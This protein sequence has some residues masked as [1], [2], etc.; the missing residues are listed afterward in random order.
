MKYP[1]TQVFNVDQLRREWEEEVYHELKFK[2]MNEFI[3]ALPMKILYPTFSIY[4]KMNFLK[5]F[6]NH[7]RFSVTLSI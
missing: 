1:V 5:L 2:L 3:F 4:G 6:S 7:C